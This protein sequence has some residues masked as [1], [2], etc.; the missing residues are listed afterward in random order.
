MKEMGTVEYGGDYCEHVGGKWRQVGLEP[1]PDAP[2]GQMY[3]ASPHS[4]DPSFLADEDHA[5]HAGNFATYVARM[6]TK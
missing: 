4:D 5:Y 2:T 1:N 3:I 6:R